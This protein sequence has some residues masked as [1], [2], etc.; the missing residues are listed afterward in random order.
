VKPFAE[1]SGGF[2]LARRVLAGGRPP[3]TKEMDGL[4]LT[5]MQWESIVA[6]WDQ[7][8]SRRPA[9]SSEGGP[10]I[11]SWTPETEMVHSASHQPDLSAE[12]ALCALCSFYVLMM[13]YDKNSFRQ[14]INIFS[15]IVRLG[16]IRIHRHEDALL[17]SIHDRV[18]VKQEPADYDSPYFKIFLLLQ[19]H[20]SGL[21]LSPE[22]AADLTIVLERIFSLF[23][24]RAHNDWSKSDYD[25]LFRERLYHTIPLM[26]MC[27]HGMWDSDSELKQI[28]HF[29]DN[30]SGSIKC[31]VFG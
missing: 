4:K 3:R 29:E 7:E 6:A 13:Q 15:F 22:L 23:S 16:R 20:F 24:V 9:L 10:M 19:A 25:L 11:F 1:L 28:P 18:L 21:P 2:A 17:R 27:V 31:L 14:V 12:E 26:R 5:D 8:A 30:V